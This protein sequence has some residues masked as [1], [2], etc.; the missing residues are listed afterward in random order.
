MKRNTVRIAQSLLSFLLKNLSVY[1]II[2][3][4][5]VGCATTKHLISTDSQ[6]Q[7]SIINLTDA[8]D[9]INLASLLGFYEICNSTDV[10]NVSSFK[11]PYFY[12]VDLSYNSES[13]SSG[14]QGI[15]FIAS[16]KN[17]F[18]LAKNYDSLISLS[19]RKTNS[20]YDEMQLLIEKTKA[21]VEIKTLEDGSIEVTKSKIGNTDIDT[22]REGIVSTIKSVLKSKKIISSSWQRMEAGISVRVVKTND[23]SISFKVFNLATLGSGLKDDSTDSFSVTAKLDKAQAGGFSCYEYP[24]K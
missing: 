18:S 9:A 22:L 6:R 20:I 12:A 19:Y 5:T 23:S 15:E 3:T 2:S 11:I 21:D 4:L 13:I 8:I 14:A 1:L 17:S 24:G 7:N 16:S 10:K